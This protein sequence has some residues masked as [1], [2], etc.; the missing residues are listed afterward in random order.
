MLQSGFIT[1]LN[2]KSS[3]LLRATLNQKQRSRSKSGTRKPSAGSVK[4]FEGY[5]IQGSYKLGT[6]YLCAEIWVFGLSFTLKSA[7]EPNGPSGWR[8]TPV[9][10][11]RSDWEYCYSPLDWDASPSSKWPIRHEATGNTA[12]P[13]GWYASPLQ[14]YSPISYCWHPFIHLDEDRLCGVR[15]LV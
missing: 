1:P 3:K 13:A 4:C 10:V 7:Y 2:D 8:L 9:S 12:I 15:F 11:A 14:G 6:R 5:G